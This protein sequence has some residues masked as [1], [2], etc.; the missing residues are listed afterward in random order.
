MNIDDLELNKQVRKAVKYFWNTRLNQT[1]NQG[2]LTGKKDQGGR[3]AVTGG[4]Q[5][6]G[7]ELLVKQ[8]LVKAGIKEKSILCTN[9]LELPG[10]FRPEKKWDLL[11]IVEGKLLAVS[12]HFENCTL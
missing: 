5:M 12:V 1:T 11:V 8:L 3:Q 4:K 6:A 2:E 9:R 7:F 10:Y